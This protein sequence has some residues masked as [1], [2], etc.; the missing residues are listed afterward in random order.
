MLHAYPVFLSKSV[1]RPSSQWKIIF[2][3]LHPRSEMEMQAARPGN[4][5]QENYSD[6]SGCTCEIRG[7]LGLIGLSPKEMAK[8]ALFEFCFS[9]KYSY[10]LGCLC[11]LV[12]VWCFP[13]RAGPLALT[14]SH[15]I[16]WKQWLEGLPSIFSPVVK[17]KTINTIHVFI[18][19]RMYFPC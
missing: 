12:D 8:P 3:S 9:S 16:S 7:L 15:C 5:D 4:Q 11:E 19:F 6:C 14:D 2:G 18:Y 17:N 13:S 10:W 1:I